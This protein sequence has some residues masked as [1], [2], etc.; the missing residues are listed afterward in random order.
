MLKFTEVVSMVCRLEG[1]AYIAPY[2]TAIADWP[3]ET[4]ATRWRFLVDTARRISEGTPARKAAGQ[5][6]PEA[7]WRH[8]ADVGSA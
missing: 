6:Y 5:A 4:R 8:I 3:G 2:L 7:L 1:E